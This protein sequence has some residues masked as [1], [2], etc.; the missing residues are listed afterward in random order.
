MRD[1]TKNF[2]ET[3]LKAVNKKIQNKE[4]NIQG[5]L[6]MLG[7]GIAGMA[8]GI[9]SKSESSFI[10][11]MVVCSGS[12]LFRVINVLSLDRLKYTQY[13]LKYALK[14]DNVIEYFED[15]Y[16]GKHFKK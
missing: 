3:S 1:E 8:Y 5:G 7:V 2:L 13:S 15:D 11:G 14:H 9:L 10:S 12:V 6:Y 4:D 16:E